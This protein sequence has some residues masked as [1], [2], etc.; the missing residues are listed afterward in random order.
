M[1]SIPID[2][3]IE[4]MPELA[5][6]VEAG[7]T[8]VVTRDGEP[9]FD[10]KPHPPKRKGGIDFEAGRRW[11]EERGITNP[12]PWISPDFDNPLPEDFLLRPLPPDA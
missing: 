8:I 4:R 1:K 11:L 3:V 10:M 2:D 7:E 6:E 12:V 5:R 9:V